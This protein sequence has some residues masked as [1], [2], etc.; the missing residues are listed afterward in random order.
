M[1]ES[2]QKCPS[3]SETVPLEYSVCPFCGFGLLEYELKKFSFKPSLREVFIRLYAYFRHPFKTSEEIAIATEKKGGNIILFLFSLFL[4]LRYYMVMVKSGVVYS[5][6]FEIGPGGEKWSIT[7]PMGFILFLVTLVIMPLVVWLMYKIFLL[8]ATWLMA[9]FAA[10]LG[11]EATTKQFRS[12]IGYSLAAI[13]VGEF[14]GIFFTLMGPSG[15]L[16]SSSSVDFIDFAGYINNLYG[17]PAMWIFKGIM[18]VLWLVFIIYSSI[19]L[20]IIG[21]MAWVNAFVAIAMPVALFVF[22]FYFSGVL[23]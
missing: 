4:S 12:I 1:S 7:I 16:G 11:S 10:I 23:T 17:S 2:T 13:T 8:I 6:F 18:V 3:C 21:K 19:S 20:R 15:G 5:T 9:K 14:L 22:F